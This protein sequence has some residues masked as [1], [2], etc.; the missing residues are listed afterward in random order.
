[1]LYI[2]DDW[3]ALIRVAQDLVK[4]AQDKGVSLA[5][6]DERMA[7]QELIEEAARFGRPAPSD[8]EVAEDSKSVR[9][10]R[11]A[12]LR[13][14][15]AAQVNDLLGRDPLEWPPSI[16]GMYQGLLIWAEAKLLPLSDMSRIELTLTVARNAG[17]W[18]SQKT[19]QYDSW[20]GKLRGQVKSLREQRKLEDLKRGA[21]WSSDEYVLIG[22]A[23]NDPRFANKSP[24]RQVQQRLADLEQLELMRRCVTTCLNDQE[25]Q[26]IELYYGNDL[27]YREI[28]GMTGCSTGN[29]HKKLQAVLAKLKRSMLSDKSREDD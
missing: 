4:L 20:E 12:F 27:T 6:A 7:D 3:E 17:K 18:H 26:L 29:A 19:L 9:D 5:L 28:G 23:T 8:Q 2:T 1:M 25:R 15:R 22:D 21:E 16:H 13:K 14:K 11:L 10:A 24:H